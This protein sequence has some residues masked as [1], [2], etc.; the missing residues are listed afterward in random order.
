MGRQKCLPRP[1]RFN[2]SHLLP[3]TSPSV[4]SLSLSRFND[5]YLETEYPGRLCRFSLSSI[6][7]KYNKI[8][9]APR[10]ETVL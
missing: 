4:V 10:R 6:E 1:P 7:L 5:P 9:H 8:E 3:N 2:V